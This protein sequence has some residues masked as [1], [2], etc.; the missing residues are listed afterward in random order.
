MIVLA[1]TGPSQSLSRAYP[2]RI[3]IFHYFSAY[4]PS[5]LAKTI[6]H[7][8]FAGQV[9]IRK[10]PRWS[11]LAFAL[12]YEQPTGQLLSYGCGDSGL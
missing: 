2:L 6:I 5:G 3:I 9:L 12:K 11:S 10:E 1:I 4:H 7:G 8:S